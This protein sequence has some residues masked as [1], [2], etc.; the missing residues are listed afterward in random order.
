[1]RLFTQDLTDFFAKKKYSSGTLKR[2]LKLTRLFVDYLSDHINKSID[3]VDLSRIITIMDVKGQPF[4]IRPLN[5]SVIDLYFSFLFQ[6]KNSYCTLIQTRHVLVSFFEFLER[7]YNF[8]NP[9]S[10]ITFDFKS[11]KPHSV[12]RDCFSRHEILKLF[13]AIITHSCN[14]NRD[15]IFFSFL[16]STGRRISEV[17]NLKV[18]HFDF[19]LNS[20]KLVH[21][22]S[23][24][25]IVCPLM[26]GM[27]DAIELYCK[28]NHYL[29]TDYLIQRAN[30]TAFLSRQSLDL[31]HEYC[32]LAGIKK[33]GLHDTRHSFA[34]L[35]YEENVDIS[36]IQQFLDHVRGDTTQGYVKQNYVRNYGLKIE[37]N[38]ELY[39]SFRESDAKVSNSLGNRF[40]IV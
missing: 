18:E 12:R 21:T 4:V 37:F 20:Y 34:T 9:M 30:G 15:L 5:E 32:D 40:P 36:I 10:R 16:L 6:E 25:Q 11:L 35:L 22:K 26:D 27:G 13:N 14:L 3:E 17:T 19:R 8:T 1:M 7:N 28:Q 38:Q 23:N 33:H 2:Y 39:A 31:L 24:R 29:P